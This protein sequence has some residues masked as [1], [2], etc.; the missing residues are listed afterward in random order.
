[1]TLDEFTI[2]YLLYISFLD[3]S[4]L[5]MTEKIRDNLYLKYNFSTVQEFQ[6]A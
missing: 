5:R 4:N 2:Y 3:Q 1:M 6:L